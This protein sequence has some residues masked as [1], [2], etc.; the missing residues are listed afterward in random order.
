MRWINGKKTYLGMIGL[1]VLAICFEVGW[2]DPSHAKMIAYAL[3]SWT[4]V[5][6]VHKYE[7]NKKK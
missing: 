6:M 2:I 1:G 7:K 5:A 3:S 4:G